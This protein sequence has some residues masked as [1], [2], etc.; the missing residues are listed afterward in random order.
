M[1]LEPCLSCPWR[2]SNPPGGSSI[3]GFRI[4][5]M[6]RLASRVVGEGDAF[7]PIMA[8]HYSA[9]GND[10]SCRGYL[11]VCGQENINVRWL[12]AL[13][14]IDWR[15]IVDACEDIELWGSFEEMLAAYESAC[16]DEDS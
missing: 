13:D 3:P 14:E 4:E 11:V 10:T 6:R 2:R 5:L 15:G 12:I 1:S 7:R 16:G 9:R 8:C